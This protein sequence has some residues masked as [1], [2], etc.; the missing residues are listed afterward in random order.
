M[1]QA[2]RVQDITDVTLQ[3]ASLT[4]S[5]LGFT[6][7]KKTSRTPTSICCCEAPEIK[8]V[9][10]INLTKNATYE[11]EYPLTPRQVKPVL[12]GGMINRFPQNS[13]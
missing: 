4:P 3:F 13:V 7:S 12:A 2:S 11:T 8:S 1:R 10:V 5:W 6:C 9:P